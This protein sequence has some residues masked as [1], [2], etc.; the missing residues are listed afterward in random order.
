MSI[1]E[2][3][4]SKQTHMQQETKK[5]ETLLKTFIPGYVKAVSGQLLLL[6]SAAL[7]Q[8]PQCWSCPVLSRAKFTG[9]NRLGTVSLPP[10]CRRHTVADTYSMCHIQAHHSQDEITQYTQPLLH[11]FTSVNIFPPSFSLLK[12]VIML[13]AKLKLKKYGICA[14]LKWRW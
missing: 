7:L 1:K 6:R 4:C 14:C 11:C 5:S 12:V 3:L 2:K 9:W 13:H 8:W 10:C